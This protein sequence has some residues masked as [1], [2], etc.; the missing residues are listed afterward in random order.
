MEKQGWKIAAVISTILL[1][2]ILIALGSIFY[3]GAVSQYKEDIC[4]Y[5]IC[6]LRGHPELGE[7]YYAYFL[8][9]DDSCFCFR[10]GEIEVIEDVN[11]FMG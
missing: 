5:D 4:A 8:A 9:S 11:D 2:L 7:I 3:I 1:I 6:N 10:D